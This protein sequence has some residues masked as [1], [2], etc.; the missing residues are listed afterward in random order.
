MYSES[1][2]LCEH[3]N[4]RTLCFFFPPLWCLSDHNQ[5]PDSVRHIMHA[6]MHDP[7]HKSTHQIRWAP[8]NGGAAIRS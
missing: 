8:G 7:Q 5:P 4:V 2:T 1:L 3:P 6:C